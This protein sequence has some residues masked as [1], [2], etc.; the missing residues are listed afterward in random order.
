[1]GV[2]ELALGVAYINDLTHTANLYIWEY[3]DTNTLNVSL[4]AIVVHEMVHILVQPLKKIYL[5]IVNEMEGAAK[6]L[7][8]MFWNAAEETLVN[9]ITRITLESTNTSYVADKD[10]LMIQTLATLFNQHM[11]EILKKGK[12]HQPP[13]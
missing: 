10:Y 7:M 2:N 3:A 12:K 9:Q 5:I 6:E 1:M 11:G 13:K 8:L 4:E